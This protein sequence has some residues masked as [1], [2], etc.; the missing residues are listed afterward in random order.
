MTNVWLIADSDAE[1]GA[2]ETLPDTDSLIVLSRSDFV[3]SDLDFRNGERVCINSEAAMVDVVSRFDPVRQ[4]AVGILKD[5]HKF[6]E[7]LADFY[8]DFYFAEVATSDLPGIT[9]DP[10]KRYVVK[11]TLGCFGAAVRTIRGDADLSMLAGEI[12]TDVARNAAVLSTSVLSSEKV[13]IEQYIEGEEYA[14]DMFYDS[15]GQPVITNAYHHPMPANPAYLHMVYYSSR[16]VYER[17]YKPAIVFL[18][19]LNTISTLR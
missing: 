8:P 4:R 2:I 1:A 17:L 6:R 13:I 12:E 3:A 5:K 14:I 7:A 11:P 10:E 19:K 16:E 15:A 18:K 9:L